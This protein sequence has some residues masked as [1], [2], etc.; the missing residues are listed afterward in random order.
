VAC[1]ANTTRGGVLVVGVVDDGSGP[2]ALVGS[3]L[4]LAWLRERI[5]ALTT[6]HYSGFFIEEVT[7]FGPRLYF[8]K[9]EPALEEIRAGDRLRTRHGRRCVEL[10][11]DAA[12]RFPWRTTAS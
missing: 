10:T 12:R 2:D 6:P 4:D 3:Y 1:F 11:G 5:W 8:V 7:T 9:V